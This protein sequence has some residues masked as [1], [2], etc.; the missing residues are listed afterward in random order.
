[1]IES[2]GRSEQ[3]MTASPSQAIKEALNKSASGMK[4]KTHGAQEPEH[5]GY[6]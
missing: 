4:H 1:M 2:L 6:M 3:R 5:M